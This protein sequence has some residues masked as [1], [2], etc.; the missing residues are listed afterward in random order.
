[1]NMEFPEVRQSAV[2]A[3]V[4]G[5]AMVFLV[6]PALAGSGAAVSP[7]A[8]PEKRP[9]REFI[10]YPNYAQ[11][12]Y[13]YQSTGDFAATPMVIPPSVPVIQQPAQL[14]VQAPP[15][16][17]PLAMEMG[18]PQ[19]VV[20]GGP[21][22]GGNGLQTVK[23]SAPMSAGSMDSAHADL[24]MRQVTNSGVP[25]YRRPMSHNGMTWEQIHA[26]PFDSHDK[27]THVAKLLQDRLQIQ[28]RIVTH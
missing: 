7:E 17:P 14:I 9:L 18:M 1:M 4:F 19:Q 6:A 11:S 2:S 21:S 24:L 23:N 25:A 15:P 27:V 13:N 28:G 10:Y 3:A 12:P 22:G 8:T 20:M 16:L 26:G 5:L